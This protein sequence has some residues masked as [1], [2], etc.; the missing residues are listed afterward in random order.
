MEALPRADTAQTSDLGVAQVKLTVSR[1]LGWVFRELPNPDFGIDGQIEIL[2]EAAGA[3]VTTGR[4]LSVQVKG[5]SAYFH[6]EDETGWTVYIAK[7]TVHYWCVHS[8]PVLVV[9]AKLDTGECFWTRGDVPDLKATARNYKIRVPKD[10]RLDA[11]AIPALLD[12]T[13]EK[14]DRL[15]L[16]ELLAKIGLEKGVPAAPLRRLLG[17]LGEVGVT[18]SQI[19][20]RLD[21]KATE[22]LEF[23]NRWE[24]EAQ[25]SSFGAVQREALRLIDQGEFQAARAKLQRARRAI[26]LQHARET[27]SLIAVEAELDRL[28]LRYSVAAQRYAEAEAAVIRLDPELR[29]KYL[30]LRA[31][32]LKQL[33]EEFGDTIALRESVTLRRK[34]VALSPRKR[35]PL[36]WADCKH[37]LGNSLRV[38]GART[39]EGTQLSQALS[40]YRQ[41]LGERTRDRVPQEWSQTQHC[42]GI[43]LRLIGIRRAEPKLIEGAVVAFRLAL[44]ERP[45]NRFPEEWASSQVSLANALQSLGRHESSTLR[46][47][48]A[49]RAYERA[50]EV[51]SPESALL[52][53][54]RAQIKRA[55]ALRNLGER[56][57]DRHLLS[58]SLRVCDEVLIVLPVSRAPVLWAMTQNTVGAV[59]RNLGER[60]ARPHASAPQEDDWFE[61]DAVP[62]SGILA[63]AVKAFHSALT[64]YTRERFPVDWATTQNDLGC[65][66]RAMGER[67]GDTQALTQAVASFRG[68]LEVIGRTRHPLWWAIIQSNLG[69]SLRLLAQQNSDELLLREA[70]DA[71]LLALTVRSRERF[72]LDWAITQTN[73]ADAFVALGE[74]LVDSESREKAGN[75]YS[76]AIEVFEAVKADHWIG[77]AQQGL[78]RA[79][80]DLEQNGASYP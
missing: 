15:L 49:L 10:Q 67:E 69:N 40:A 38:L 46:M 28:E 26:R 71:Q 21:A 25:V 22:L 39:P 58:E 12:L 74:L 55:Q 30:R 43:T 33:G 54:T 62:P 8:L 70:I 3:R 11:A 9:L 79:Y 45:P 7:S 59:L 73:L 23:R 35:V 6:K 1:D 47:H 44:E 68:A 27:A 56:D 50:L 64:V 66:L 4:L 18:D 19:P 75:A 51:Y 14:K 5:G 60:E 65:A 57:S 20:E 53:W 52:S 42:I 37:G 17:R 72:P 61:G 36:V 63:E 29:R 24:R 31:V 80:A 76:G 34:A 41:A 78:V 16:E 13:V 2:T 32:T 77:L 48:E